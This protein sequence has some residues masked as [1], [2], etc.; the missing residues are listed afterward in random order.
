MGKVMPRKMKTAAEL[1][2][3]KEKAARLK[4]QKQNKAKRDRAKRQRKEKEKRDKKKQRDRKTRDRRKEAKKKRDREAAARKRERS[5]AAKVRRDKKQKQHAKKIAANKKVSDALEDV[6]QVQFY[7]LLH[8]P[9]NFFSI[10][11]S[12]KESGWRKRPSYA[13]R[14]RRTARRRLPKLF[15]VR[16]FHARTAAVRKSKATK[17]TAHSV[18]ICRVAKV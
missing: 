7:R 5:R 12:R 10:T 18:P 16:R 9:K 14:R 2:R 13:S 8:E 11:Y 3:E 15:P 4:V 6:T 17:S 1:R